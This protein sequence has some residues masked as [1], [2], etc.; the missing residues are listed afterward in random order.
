M[1]LR[2]LG[3]GGCALSDWEGRELRSQRGATTGNHHALE[4]FALVDDGR[5]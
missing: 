5:A 3:V 4:Q 2:A 1:R